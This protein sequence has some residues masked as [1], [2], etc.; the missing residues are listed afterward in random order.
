MRV[1]VVDGGEDDLDE[2]GGVGGEGSGAGGPPVGAVVLRAKSPVA[3]VELRVMGEWGGVGEGE[4][5]GGA[6]AV[7]RGW[8]RSRCV[9]GVRRRPVSGEAGSGEVEGVGAAAGGG[10]EGEGGGLEGGGGGDELEAEP[11]VGA[12]SGGGGRE[13]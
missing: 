10:G 1:P 9:T 12:G 8:G 5:G 3:V 13:G 2:A 11:A 6:G 4:E 7:R